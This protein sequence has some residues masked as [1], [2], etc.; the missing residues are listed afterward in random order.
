MGITQKR[1]ILV[2]DAGCGKS[3]LALRLTHS[4]FAESYIPTSFDSLDTELT[5]AS[6]CYKLTLQDTSGAREN[7]EVRKMAYEGCDVAIVCFDLA[8]KTSYEN[9]ETRWLP[10]LSL[11]CPGIPVIVAGCKRDEIESDEDAAVT[12]KETEELI[13]RVG[14]MGYL[15]CSARTNENIQKLFQM[16][17]EAKALK[18]RSGVNKI[19]HSVK[20]TTSKTIRRSF[21][22]ATAH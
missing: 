2:G 9:I 22:A 7:G 3:A 15:E 21:H 1:I 10:E 11:S 13:E 18:H 8:N 6:G 14:A 19:L 17:V 5:T 16:A 4:L 12:I 20:S